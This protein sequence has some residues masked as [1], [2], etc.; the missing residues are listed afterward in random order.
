MQSYMPACS[1]LE[2]FSDYLQVEYEC[3]SSECLSEPIVAPVK[4]STNLESAC[5][6]RST[7]D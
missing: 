6:R 5:L 1:G 4:P 7:S 2:K 3:V